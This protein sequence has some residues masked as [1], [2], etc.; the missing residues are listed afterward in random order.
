[1]NIRSFLK[2]SESVNKAFPN[3]NIKKWVSQ[4]NHEDIIVENEDFVVE[5][6]VFPKERQV[7][8]NGE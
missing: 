3:S 8:S 1:M 4:D 6:K 7:N 5:L 2:L